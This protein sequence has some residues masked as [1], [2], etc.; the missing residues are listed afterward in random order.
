MYYIQW[1][2]IHLDYLLNNLQFKQ[3]IILQNLQRKISMFLENKL[4]H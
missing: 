3:V 2:L 1:D 4:N